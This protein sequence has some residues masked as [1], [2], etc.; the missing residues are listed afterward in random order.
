MNGIPLDVKPCWFNPI[1]RLQS[2]AAKNNGMAVVVMKFLVN[3]AGEP[4]YWTEPKITFVEPSRQRGRQSLL[5]L[6]TE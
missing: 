2:V 4:L 5:D 1:R 6:F 3:D